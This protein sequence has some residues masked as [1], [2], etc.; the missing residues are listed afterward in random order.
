MATQILVVD[1]EQDM[2]ALLKR[3]ITEKTPFDVTVASDP[4]KVGELLSQNSF[5][6]VI[7]D[8]KMPR[9]DGIQVLELVK[10]H[11]NGI[12][13]IIMTAYGTIESAIEAT[14]KGAF[15]Y[16]TKPFRK[17]RVLHVLEQALKWRSLQQ[18]NTFL[19]Q[20]LQD[21]SAFSSLIGNS[22]AMQRLHGQID[23]VARATATILI[24][25]ESG[26]GK[27]LVAR[28]IH[29]H[30]HR[31]DKLFTPIDCS[32]IPESLMESELFGHLRGSFTG[33]L[34]D[35]RGLVEETNHGTLFL[36]EIGDL[37][38]AMQVK[39]LRLLQEG[40]YKVVGDTRIRKVDI[41]FLAATHQNLADKIRKGEF[42]ED[43]FYRLNV[44]NIHLPPLRERHDD[45]PLLAH[46]FLNKYA[47]LNGKQFQGFTR[48]AMN[49]LIQ[50]EWPGNIR[51]LENVVERG[52][53][54]A[55]G[56]TITDNDLCMP[57][58]HG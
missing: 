48:D 1:D 11:N 15:D 14:R 41:R 26:T 56:H 44:I 32:T 8:L 43:L 37:N 5:A 47:V 57:G 13:V 25:G 19:R 46:H 17:E 49:F 39:L 2:L 10:Q 34:K 55:R 22:P 12:A 50:Q 27:E 4:S 36:D 54:L 53:I 16:I 33:A 38:P 31:K 35:K 29:H 52:V 30:S 7:T 18:E 3:I 40:E 58:A 6:V 24:T 20:K 51:E 21:K 23:Q 42:R 9:L 28:A 45:I